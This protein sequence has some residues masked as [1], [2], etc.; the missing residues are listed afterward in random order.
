M[1][2]CGKQKRIHVANL[3]ENLMWQNSILDFDLRYDP[4]NCFQV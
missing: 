1:T 4:N 2:S 3:N